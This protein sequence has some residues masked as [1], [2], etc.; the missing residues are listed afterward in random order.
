MSPVATLDFFNLKRIAKSWRVNTAGNVN[1]C[2][3]AT[4]TRGCFAIGLENERGF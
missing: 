2:G 3:D 4:Y 1:A